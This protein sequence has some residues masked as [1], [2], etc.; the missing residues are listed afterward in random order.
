MERIRFR[1][2]PDGLVV[3][4]LLV[5]CSSGGEGA[6]NGPGVSVKVMTRNVYLGGEFDSLIGAQTMAQIPGMVDTFWKGVQTSNFPARAALIT[7]EVAAEM[8]DIVA[9]QELELFRMQTPSDFDPKAAPNAADTAPNGDLLAILTAALAARGLDYGEPVAVATHTDTEMP[10]ADASSGATYDLRLTDR[11]AVFARPGLTV[12][13]VRTADFPT[14]ISLPVPLSSLGAGI[15]VQLKRGYAAMD[16]QA[17]G[18]PF[19]FAATHLEV[20]GQASAYQEGEARDLVTALAPIAGPLVLVGDFNSAAN[21]PSTQSYSIVTQS[22]TD[23]WSQ[24]N[25]TDTAPTCCTD[26][27]SPAPAPTDRID[28]VLYRG[29]VHPQAAERTGTDPAE[30]TASGLLPSDHQG[31]AAALTI[32]P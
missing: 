30:R 28:L 14:Y 4:T 22:F 18:V 21:L 5:G 27:A 29:H 1:W 25:P 15:L 6:W 7:D 26:I 9:F 23:A 16:V 19:T 2:L 11:D 32:G 8:P 17:G 31:V 20:G 24:V 10:G 13:N 3:I 12:S